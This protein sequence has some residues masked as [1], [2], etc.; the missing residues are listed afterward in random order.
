MKIHF[1]GEKQVPIPSRYVVIVLLA[2]LAICAGLGLSNYSRSDIS[3]AP[4]GNSLPAGAAQVNRMLS[5]SNTLESAGAVMQNIS[6]RK[7]KANACDLLRSKDIQSVQGEALKDAKSS[8]RVEGGIHISQCFY[9]LTT[10]S[11]SIALT[12][13]ARES[14]RFARDPKDFWNETFHR[15]KD[16]RESKESESGER[17]ASAEMISGIGDEAFWTGS[18]VGGALYVLKGNSFIRLSIGGSDNEPTRIRKSKVLAQLVL[19]HM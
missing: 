18:R 7:G 15:D 10:F 2:C 16:R 8:D 6:M 19:K 4:I 1:T 14:G 5:G 17:E 3:R 13:M 9:S 11:K 12:V